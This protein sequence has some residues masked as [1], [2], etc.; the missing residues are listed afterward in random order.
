MGTVI[1]FFVGI[2]IGGFFGML[3]LALLNA[4]KDDKNDI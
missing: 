1:A 3:I 4:G 2:M